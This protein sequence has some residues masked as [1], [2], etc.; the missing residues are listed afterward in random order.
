MLSMPRIV[1]P[2]LFRLRG[3]EIGFPVEPATRRSIKR[4]KE[5]AE[6]LT[7]KQCSQMGAER[8]C[9]RGRVRGKPKREPRY[10][11]RTGSLLCRRV[12]GRTVRRVRSEKILGRVEMALLLSTFVGMVHNRRCLLRGCVCLR[13]PGSSTSGD[14][15]ISKRGVDA[16]A[17]DHGFK[18]LLE[19]AVFSG[20]RPSVHFRIFAV[21]FS[22]CNRVLVLP[23]PG[24]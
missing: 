10:P 2:D 3:T 9:E 16:A 19:C 4:H 11:Y 13:L 17:I 21:L 24:R 8:G 12:I 15:A 18:R 1:R 23:E 6:L 7:G 22:Y 14:A 20:K 5:L